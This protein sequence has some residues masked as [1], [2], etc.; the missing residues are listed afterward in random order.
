MPLRTALLFQADNFV[1][2]EYLDALNGAGMPPDLIAT[3]GRMSDAS[4]VRERER[5]G[6]QW[7]PPAPENARDISHFDSLKEEALWESLRDA[8][9]DLAIQ[10]G[11]GILTPEM[12]EVPRI[13]FVNVHPGRLPEYKGNTCPE[14]ALYNGDPIFATAHI[15]DAGIDTGPVVCEGRYEVPADWDYFEL[16]ANLYR[17]C[18]HVLIN[19]LKILNVASDNPHS[20]LTVQDPDAGHYWTP[21]PE[22]KLATVIQKNKGTRKGL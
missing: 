6:G 12:L 21:I 20:V 11:I 19:A 7:N 9:I 16:R 17:H 5:T 8:Q 15:I 14:W 1:G 13:G 10:G 18:A 4:V 22:D 3:V 2:R